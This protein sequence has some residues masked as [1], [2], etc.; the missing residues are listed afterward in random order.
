MGL[1]ILDTGKSLIIDDTNFASKHEQYWRIISSTMG[2]PMDVINFDVPV[3]E[4]IKRDLKREKPV[5]KAVILNM[6]EKFIK[7]KN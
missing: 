4:C 3:E 2:I 1:A 5:G 7:P 6:Y